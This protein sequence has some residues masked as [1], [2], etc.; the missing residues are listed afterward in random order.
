MLWIRVFQHSFRRLV[1]A[2]RVPRAG[3]YQAQLG[4]YYVPWA[5]RISSILDTYALVCVPFSVSLLP[6]S[7]LPSGSDL[8]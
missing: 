8:D 1:E 6:T 3:Y 7:T 4:E 2:T 5:Q